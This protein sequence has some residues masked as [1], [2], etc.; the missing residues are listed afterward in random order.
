MQDDTT[1][2]IAPT[3]DEDTT[4]ETAVETESAPE[5]ANGEDESA[6]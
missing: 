1:T 3:G 2:P 4:E 6:A 5:V